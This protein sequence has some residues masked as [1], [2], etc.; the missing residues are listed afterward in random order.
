M[1]VLC[2]D[3]PNDFADPERPRGRESDDIVTVPDHGKWPLLR[4]RIVECAAIGAESRT[5]KRFERRQGVVGRDPPDIFR[6][7]DPT[8]NTLMA[9]DLM[10]RNEAQ[11]L[12]KR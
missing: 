7:I 2:H 9:Y 10:P 11:L 4:Q 5:I 8:N 6:C 12:V 3:R 1:S